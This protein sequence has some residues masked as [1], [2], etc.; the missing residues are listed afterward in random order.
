MT[1]TIRYQLKSLKGPCVNP[2]E[3]FKYLRFVKKKEQIQ[4]QTNTGIK[5]KICEKMLS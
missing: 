2:K 4:A 5:I 1:K 3:V